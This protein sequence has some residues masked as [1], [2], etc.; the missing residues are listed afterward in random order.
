MLSV[1]VVSQTGSYAYG[2][3]SYS[4]GDLRQEPPG[5]YWDPVRDV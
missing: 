3:Q 1:E 4:A 2:S 5:T